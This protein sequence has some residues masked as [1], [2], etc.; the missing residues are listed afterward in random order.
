MFLGSYGSEEMI[1]SASNVDG[2]AWF[3]ALLPGLATFF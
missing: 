1:A 3:P 2:R